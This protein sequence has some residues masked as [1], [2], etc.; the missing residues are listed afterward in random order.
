MSEEGEI[1]P[2]PT[3]DQNYEAVRELYDKRVES[4]Q[5]ERQREELKE[6]PFSR[7]LFSEEMYKPNSNE[8]RIAELGCGIGAL[9]SSILSKDEYF[10]DPSRKVVI[11]AIDL[12]EESL[13]AY[14]KNIFVSKANAQVTTSRGA[15]KDNVRYI[16]SPLD[17]IVSTGVF[18][19]PPD[20]LQTALNSLLPKLNPG[21]AFIFQFMP[22]Q[23]QWGEKDTGA[24]LIKKGLGNYN[25]YRYPKSYL[26]KL[27]I[28]IRQELGVDFDYR[29]I[30]A[31]EITM[32][33]PLDEN[34][35][36]TS[37]SFFL[38]LHRK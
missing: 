2:N 36:I 31:P 25:S 23:E 8:V 21:G 29:F 11:H 13:D 26:D 12:S 33:H 37:R 1:E 34:K 3:S 10:A 9:T 24:Y 7:K 19:I 16:E 18:Q 35:T 4:G 6:R 32:K 17:N 22:P 38:S 14:R 30:D 27:L 20:E 15:I 28:K 5:L